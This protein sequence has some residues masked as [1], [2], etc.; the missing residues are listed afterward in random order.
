M[1]SSDRQSHRLAA[2]KYVTVALETR[3]ESEDHLSTAAQGLDLSRLREGR[4]RQKAPNANK[5]SLTPGRAQAALAASLV[6]MSTRYYETLVSFFST[7]RC[8]RLRLRAC[9]HNGSCLALDSDR[10]TRLGSMSE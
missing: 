3:R 4:F 10:N 5:G 2:P 7:P 8:C 9:V 1:C 6:I